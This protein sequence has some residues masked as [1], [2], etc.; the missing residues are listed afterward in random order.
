MSTRTLADLFSKLDAPSVA[1]MDGDFS[2]ELL[3]QPSPLAAVLGRFAV[4]R[5]LWRW[6]SKGFRPVDERTG[7][8]YNSFTVGSRVVQRYPMQ[9][10]LA[11]S[12]FDGRPAYHLIYPAYRSTCGLINMVDEV[13][14]AGEGVFLGIGTW[15]FTDAQ[16]HVPLPFLLVDRG[17]PYLGDL[18]QQRSGYVAS[19]RVVPQLGQA[20]AIQDLA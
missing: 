3:A 8:G 5:P 2:S 11:P 1:A 6:R 4:D 7:R 13:R 14:V 16:R 12:R 18:G 19:R 10:R 17:R 9:T 15:G 20:T